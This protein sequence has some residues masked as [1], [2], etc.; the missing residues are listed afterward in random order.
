MK[1]GEVALAKASPG[2]RRPN[3]PLAELVRLTVNTMDAAAAVP[4]I[5]EKLD[6]LGFGF[7]VPVFFISSGMLFDPSQVIGWCWNSLWTKRAP[8]RCLPA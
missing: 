1:R 3:R 4:H 2:V 7:F 5:R 6:A 8:M